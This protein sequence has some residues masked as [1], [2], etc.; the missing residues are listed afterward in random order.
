MTQLNESFVRPRVTFLRVTVRNAMLRFIRL[1]AEPTSSFVLPI[2][3]K[4]C[5][6]DGMSLIYDQIAFHN[7]EE[8]EA[9]PGFSGLRLQRFPASVRKAFG[10]KDHSRGRFFSHRA[11]GCE[12][13]F[14]T[15][16]K[17]SRLFISSLEADAEVIVYCGDRAH[18]RHL[19]KAG[20]MTSLFLEEP[21]F[22]QM[23]DPVMIGHQRFA[24]QVWR[25]TFNQDAVVLYHHLDAYG[26]EVRP[27][28]ADEIPARTWLAY[29]SSITFGGNV[30]FAPNSYVQRAALLLGVDVLNKGMPGSCM[31]EH[32]TA[33]YLA[34]ETWDFATLELGVNMTEHATPDEFSQR[35]GALIDLVH[36][37]NPA[38]PVF[39]IDIYTNR[40]DH[41][42]D[43]LHR[44]AKNTPQFRKAIRNHVTQM[45]NPMIRHLSA[46][47]IL[48]DT[49]GLSVDLLHP[50]DEGHLSMGENL[51]TVLRSALSK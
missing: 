46:D 33:Q 15:E 1:P 35:A 37:S 19:L 20:V 18:S 4:R 2:Q 48:S 23:V 45:N 10:F 24:P 16:G 40:A 51:A 49:T 36:E 22:F 32:E 39:T 28:R 6:S 29:G 27:P 14:V 11:A 13:R 34:S 44:S 9:V 38:R 12:L 47:S 5:Q 21:L 3:I 26:H 25:V 30:L 7:V 31:C 50:S 8:L 17:F 42:F 41:L 43:R